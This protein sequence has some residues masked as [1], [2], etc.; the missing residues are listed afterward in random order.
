[1]ILLDAYA[2]VAL[3]GAERAGADVRALLRSGDCGITSLNI[4]EA[5]DVLERVHGIDTAASRTFVDALP[6]A[7]IDLDARIAWHA[8]AL[9][10][11]HYRRRSSEVSMADCLLVA[12]ARVG[13]DRVA[14]ADPAVAVMAR[15]E[16]IGVEPLPDRGGRRPK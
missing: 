13:V 7:M 5:A 4:A 14:T 2:L 6:I 1:V 10:A 11:R 16:N 8:G 3:L 15:A 9:R 12:A